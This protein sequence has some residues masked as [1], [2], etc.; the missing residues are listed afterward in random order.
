MLRPMTVH[1]FR[2]L[3]GIVA[4]L[5]LLAACGSADAR[6]GRTPAVAPSAS[7]SW[8]RDCGVEYYKHLP[9]NPSAGNDHAY[10]AEEYVG[11]SLDGAKGRAQAAGLS[12]R[13]L[14]ADGD[15]TDRTD[16]LQQNRVNFYVEDDTVR[17]AARL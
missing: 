15:C 9:H 5:S 8:A 17:A 14:G 13:V 7:Y 1:A 16:D 6:G 11:L 12:L 2:R 10:E 4:L 3:P